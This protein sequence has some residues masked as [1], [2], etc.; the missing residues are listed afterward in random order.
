MLRK[1]I[2]NSGQV[3][4]NN[5]GTYP[6]SINEIVLH[7]SCGSFGCIVCS[8]FSLLVEIVICIFQSNF[9]AQEKMVH[10][11]LVRQT[12]GASIHY[13]PI[14]AAQVINGDL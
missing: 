3:A 4:K 10:D 1:S 8:L 11:F 2:C 9:E 14:S 12:R 5:R 7:L 6:T 13:D